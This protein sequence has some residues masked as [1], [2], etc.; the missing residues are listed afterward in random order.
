MHR[1]LGQRVFF[2]GAASH[3]MKRPW[4]EVKEEETEAPSGAVSEE[5]TDGGWAAEATDG[6]W[7][8]ASDG[9]WEGDDK[10][11]PWNEEEGEDG[12]GGAFGVEDCK[13]QPDEH[14]SSWAED[15][16]EWK[17]GWSHRQWQGSHASSASSSGGRYVKGGWLDA[18]NRFWPILGMLL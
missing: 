6:G 10:W 2:Q 11:E 9:G 7:P 1:S 12:G 15:G 16:T 18:N 3:A 17:R 8:E 14:P 5:A 13:W 4:S